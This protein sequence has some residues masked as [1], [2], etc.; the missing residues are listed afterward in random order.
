[1]ITMNQRLELIHE[2]KPHQKS[3]PSQKNRG[4]KLLYTVLLG[5][6]FITGYLQGSVTERVKKEREIYEFKNYNYQELN[7]RHKQLFN[8]PK[9]I[10]PNIEPTRK[11]SFFV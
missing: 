7:E 8:P 5:L 6:S 9:N 10:L 1:M 4:R 3:E 2:E 11:Q